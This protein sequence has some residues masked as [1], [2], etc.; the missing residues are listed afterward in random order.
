MNSHTMHGGKIFDYRDVFG[1]ICEA[2]LANN[3]E[4]IFIQMPR[5]VWPDSANSR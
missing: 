3:L 4:N 5:K 1:V 2:F